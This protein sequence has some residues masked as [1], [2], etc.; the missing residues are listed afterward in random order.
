MKGRKFGVGALL[1]VFL[2]ALL[3][4]GGCGG[5]PHNT[6]GATPNPSPNPQPQVGVL[7]GWKGTWKGFY[8][9][10]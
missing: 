5:A 2:L 7:D 10:M 6:P 9:S 4:L 8:G 1:F 3:A